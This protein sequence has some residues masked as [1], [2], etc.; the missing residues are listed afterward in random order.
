MTNIAP[1]QAMVTKERARLAGLMASGRGTAFEIAL[2]RT[3]LEMMADLLAKYPGSVLA[4]DKIGPDKDGMDGPYRWYV[5]SMHK[6]SEILSPTYG[7]SDQWARKYEDYLNFSLTMLKWGQVKQEYIEDKKNGIGYLILGADPLVGKIMG[8]IRTELMRWYDR[9]PHTKANLDLTP[10]EGLAAMLYERPDLVALLRM[11]Y[12]IPVLHETSSIPIDRPTWVEAI[13]LTVGLIPV[14]GSCVALYESWEG[15]DMFGYKLG[16]LERG[17]LAASA[18]LPTVG[19]LAKGGRALYTESRL[20]AMYG[21]DAAAW[22]RVVSAG[23]RSSVQQQALRSL[24]NAERELRTTRSLATSTAKEAATALPAAVRGGAAGAVVDQAIVDLL[25]SLKKTVPILDT[26]DAHALE[27]VL[28][29]GPNTSHLKGQLLEELVESRVVPWLSE[30]SGS[31]ALGITVP[32]G[33]KLEFL[34]G[35]LI[36]DLNGRQITDGIL[37]YR[38]KGNLVVAAVFEAKAG[39]HAARELSFARDSISG[40]TEGELTELRANAKDVWRE[41]RD[42]ARAAGQPYKKS[43]EDVMKEYALSEKG[44]Q[45]RRDIERLSAGTTGSTTLRV[46][47]EE[48]PVVFSPT[49]TKFFGVLPKGVPQA[50]ISKELTDLKVTF[51]LIGVDVTSRDLDTIAGQLVPQAKAL[52]GAA[53]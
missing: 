17:V 16:D 18:L 37:A 39:P 33:K 29:K 50:T 8:V 26:L 47:T 36:R 51:E 20:V 1:Y 31:F 13:E 32:A 5:E 6:A 10:R 46:G 12:Q 25:A 42:A 4:Y 23:E 21:H 30:R 38:D 11:A 43:V 41:Q 49:Q 14:V 7:S 2:C 27:R 19:R 40:L 52:A 35:H 48:L 15:R 53:P 28:A 9:L 22:S 3:T 44:G 45:I 34:P 24:E